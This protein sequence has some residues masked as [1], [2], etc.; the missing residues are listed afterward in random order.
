MHSSLRFAQQSGR[1]YG[2]FPRNA[3]VRYREFAKTLR[4]PARSARTRGLA[5][6]PGELPEPFC[7]RRTTGSSMP[8]AFSNKAGRH[9]V[10]EPLRA[11]AGCAQRIGCEWRGPVLYMG[12]EATTSIPI[13][14]IRRYYKALRF[15]ATTSRRAKSAERRRAILVSRGSDLSYTGQAHGGIRF[16]RW[17]IPLAC[18]KLSPNSSGPK[19]RCSCWGRIDELIRR[20][21][22]AKSVMPRPVVLLATEQAVLPRERPFRRLIT[23]G[24]FVWRSIAEEDSQRVS[25]SRYLRG[26]R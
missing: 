8:R 17:Q 20:G 22:S 1:G 18:N 26:R 23:I 5:E 4:L 21:R 24:S 25:G 11:A 12:F 3:F 2:C 19:R 16:R 15:A 6:V 14:R 7:A 9:R 13:L 10:L